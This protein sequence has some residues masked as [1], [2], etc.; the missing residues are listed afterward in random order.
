MQKRALTTMLQHLIQDGYKSGNKLKQTQKNTSFCC[1]CR[2]HTAAQGMTFIDWLIVPACTSMCTARCWLCSFGIRIRR[3]YVPSCLHT[4]SMWTTATPRA[5]SSF[6]CTVQCG[7]WSVA[8]LHPMQSTS[9]LESSQS[10]GQQ[11]YEWHD[12]QGK[13]PY[14][15]LQSASCCPTHCH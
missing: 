12:P 8:G 9:T 6:F 11:L 4:S 7:S 15:W 10:A 5:S 1:T 13:S 2:Q 14:W 3:G